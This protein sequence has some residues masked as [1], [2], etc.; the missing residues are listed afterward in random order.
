MAQGSNGNSDAELRRI[1]L[2]DALRQEERRAAVSRVAS[3]LSH[4]L[5]TPLNVIAGRAAMIGMDGMSLEEIQNYARIVEQQVRSVATTLRQVLNFGRDAVIPLETCDVRK[6][7]ARAVRVLEPVAA[8]REV[9]VQ[10]ED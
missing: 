10:V 8:A 4:A 1:E 2:L 5:G 7:L 3:T 9:T 6:V